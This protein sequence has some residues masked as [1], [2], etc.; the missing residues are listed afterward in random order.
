MP[1]DR[2]P[3]ATRVRA[4]HPH[5]EDVEDAFLLLNYFGRNKDAVVFK[6]IN[7]PRWSADQIAYEIGSE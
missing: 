3:P 2:Q 5:S 1:N 6:G 7:Q 4:I